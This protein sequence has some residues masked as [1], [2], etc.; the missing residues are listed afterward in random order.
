MRAARHTSYAFAVLLAMVDASAQT[1]YPD[2]YIQNVDWTSGDHFVVVPQAIYSPGNGGAP[3]STTGTA[4]TEFVSATQIRLTP[5]FHAG[6]LTG[7]GRFRAR[8]N[9][10]MGDPADLV[11]ITPDATH[12]QDDILHVEKWEKLEI[13]YKLTQEYQD[14]IERFFD[15][16]YPGRNNLPVPDYTAHPTAPDE[17]HDLNPYADDSLQLVM[18]LID[19]SGDTR[20]KWGFY[21]KEAEWNPIAPVQGEAM[22]VENA[23]STGLAPFNVRFRLAPD[24]EGL[25]QF[26][27]SIKAPYTSTTADI[28]LP[29]VFYT[30]YQFMCDPPLPDNPGP[31]SVNPNNDRT[32]WFDADGDSNSGDERPFFGLG[33]NMA[34]VRNDTWDENGGPPNMWYT[35]HYRDFE[36]MTLTMQQLHEVGGNFMR[37][38][39]MRNIFAP[40]WVNLGVYDAFETPEVCDLNVSANCGGGWTGDYDTGNCQYQCWAFD[41]MLDLARENNIYLQLCIDPYPP[42]IGYERFLWGAHP[43]VI[44]YLEPN[45]NT[46]GIGNPLDLTRFFYENGNPLTV[47]DERTVFYYWKRKYKY[48][49]S[50]W[51]YS[52]NL[53][54]IEPFN[55]VD[56]MLSY[57]KR[58]ML[59]TDNE[60]TAEPCK[61]HGGL[62]R[63]NVADWD[64]DEDLPVIYNQWLTDLIGFVKDP[65]SSDPV[66]SPLGEDRKL[67]MT[68][69]GLDGTGEA[70]Y[71][72]PH[73]NP[74]VDLGDVHWG[75]FP[76]LAVEMNTVDRKIHEGWQH[77]QDCMANFPVKPFNQGE[78]THYTNF[79]I[80]NQIPG[81]PDLWSNDVEKIFHNYDVSFHNELWSSAFS[82]KFAAGTTWGWDRVFWWP[83]ALPEAYPDLGSPI[84]QT[85][86]WSGH[87]SN[88]PGASNYLDING[89]AKEV[90]NGKLHHHFTPLA[91]FLNRPSVV[92]LGVFSGNFTPRKY[93]DPS[94]VDPNPIQCYYLQNDW[95]IAI[96]WV[97]N[98]NASVAKSFYV[99][100]G[101][102]NQ[103]FLGCTAP[104]S[105]SITLTGFFPLH[106]HYITWFPTRTGSTD[107]PPDTEFPNTLMSTAAGDLT[108][109]LSGHF[110]GI[111]DNYLDTLH[112]DYAF[113]ITPQP[114][115]K[116]L[117]LPHAE[118]PSSIEA[119]WD[120]TLYPNPSRNMLTVGFSDESVKEV[121]LMDV[122]GRC[123]ARYSNI[124][125]P[126]LQIPTDQCARGLYWVMVGSSDKRKSKKLIIH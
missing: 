87:F 120:F 93:F 108:I 39:L 46:T 2:C 118:D 16:Y 76:D 81:Q 63:E 35:F 6:D 88:Q 3:A 111:A 62:C 22:L 106:A 97:H 121:A 60:N 27:L 105:A 94:T 31:L 103:N 11:F 77:A 56:Q 53:P 73:Q 45:R 41:K 12:V 42:I 9:P 124:T 13:G 126:S 32:L 21:M 59:T 78:Y 109:D 92:E 84:F 44:H 90:K 55:E 125:S 82:G 24:E 101:A 26:A 10:W 20:M 65:V 15:A 85:Y 51:G 7:E 37:M 114:F 28:A 83:Y 112:S 30:G 116:S 36:D 19:P 38:F 95:S 4:N 99:K 17:L 123:V 119:G 91:D 25:W 67:F 122:S 64:Y 80:P 71:Y 70:D 75:M 74:R 49:M 40:E 34:D 29:E 107:L 117:V 54:I 110:N 113:V 100:S 61:N 18:T 69:T 58:Y 48:I 72:L 66:H 79:T 57:R 50:R 52:V 14:A 89:N 23:S 8:I 104:T 5:G 96:G 68:G 33:V 86:H 43:Y 98:R 102:G 1:T 115:V 47:D